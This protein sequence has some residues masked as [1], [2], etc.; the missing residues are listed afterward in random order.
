MD[1]G[2]VLDG[3]FGE[4]RSEGD[5]ARDVILAVGVLDI[6][7]G[8]GQVLEIHVDIRHRDSVRIQETLEQELVLD[9]IQ[10]GDSQAIC[11]HG[12]RCGTTSRTDHTSLRP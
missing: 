3:T 8:Q 10:I 5:H 9:R 1:S 2:H 7:M 11:H 12:S 6:F 4:H